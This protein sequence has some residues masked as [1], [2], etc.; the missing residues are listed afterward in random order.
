MPHGGLST[1]DT[2]NVK[3][4][5]VDPFFQVDEDDIGENLEPV[6][7]TVND[8]LAPIPHLTR[9]A[10]SWLRKLVLVNFWL[11]P[12]LLF[13]NKINEIAISGKTNEEKHI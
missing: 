8:N 3:A 13:Y 1:D 12:C 7:A 6:P 11:R 2:R 9:V 5:F 4:E 10:H